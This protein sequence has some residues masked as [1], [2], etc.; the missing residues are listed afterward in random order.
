MLVTCLSG[1]LGYDLSGKV[2]KYAVERD[3]TLK[4]AAL[5]LGAISEEDFDRVVRPELML[6][7]SDKPEI[8]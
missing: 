4:E 1:T 8:A 2:A 6:A 5:E 3:L 7:P